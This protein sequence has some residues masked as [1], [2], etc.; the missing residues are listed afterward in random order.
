MNRSVLAVPRHEHKRTH[1]QI[2]AHPQQESGLPFEPASST[3]LTSLHAQIPAITSLTPERMLK[4]T[5]AMHAIV[6]V[7]GLP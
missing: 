3:A 1:R 2:P 4:F 7:P 5:P 6:E